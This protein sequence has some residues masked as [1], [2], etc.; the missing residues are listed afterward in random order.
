[1]RRILILII[2]GL[3]ILLP[4]VTWA[5]SDTRGY[6][7]SA[8]NG[9]ALP[10]FTNPA[11]KPEEPPV[12]PPL[13]PLKEDLVGSPSNMIKIPGLNYTPVDKQYAID[14]NGFLYLPWIGEYIAAIYQY[15][16]AIISIVAVIM[17][18]VQGVRIVTSMGGDQKVQGYK[19]I[20]RIVIGLVIAWSSYLVLN[21]INPDLV[22]FKPL[23]IKYIAEIVYG[24][25]G[26]DPIDM[27]STPG[28]PID[29]NMKKECQDMLAQPNGCP[30]HLRIGPLFSDNRDFACSY[31]MKDADYKINNTVTADWP[32]EMGT[33]VIAPGD[34]SASYSPNSK[35]CG[36]MIV[37]TFTQE[38]GRGLI[39]CHLYGD[40]NGAGTFKDTSGIHVKKGDIIGY[41]GGGRCDQGAF[42][43]CSFRSS[44]TGRPCQS[45]AAA[46]CTTG[47]HLHVQ[48]YP[49]NAFPIL[50]CMEKYQK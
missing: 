45:P 9:A 27:S 4:R 21:T 36:N 32:A 10:N 47:P 48:A 6:D 5:I 31:H 42:P 8:N 19:D 18:I 40:A 20:G 17:I 16:M 11:P 24:G 38:P 34:G 37:F 44:Y 49:T 50:A 46:G 35:G 33:P 29:P 30:L 14:E 25:R 15:S 43:N 1:M 12:V 26:G 2:G 39:L 7:Y 41:T 28:G 22:N 3:L 23:K 13:T